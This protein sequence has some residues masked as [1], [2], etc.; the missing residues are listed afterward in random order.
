MISA[1]GWR[2]WR[3]HLR[4]ARAVR[5]ANKAS[6]GQYEYTPY[7]L[8]YGESGISQIPRKYTGHDPDFTSMLYYAP[9]RYYNP[10]VARWMTRDPL[11]MVD[12]IN[13]V[14][15]CNGDPIRYS[16]PSGLLWQTTCLLAAVGLHSAI[17][18]RA[19]PDRFAHC[20]AS[21]FLT[22]DFGERCARLAGFLKEWHDLT[23]V[24]VIF[25][26]SSIDETMDDTAGDF[27]A[28]ADGIDIGKSACTY[29]DCK[30]KCNDTHPM[31]EY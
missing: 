15:Y 16:D 17:L 26:G 11:R 6:L 8:V 22:F 14:C 12:G 9:F 28:K 2:T 25:Q 1:G 31:S 10:V 18:K 24:Q 27:E 5:D 13:I 3:Q 29:R 30:D 20:L 4:L 19:L 23:I 21:C 7:G